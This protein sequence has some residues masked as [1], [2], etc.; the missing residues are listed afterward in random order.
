MIKDRVG[1]AKSR[2]HPDSGTL[3]QS[4]N[5]EFQRM[6]QKAASSTT[7]AQRIAKLETR[8]P[9]DQHDQKGGS[10]DKMERT[11]GHKKE[12]LKVIAEK[13][14]LEKKLIATPPELPISQNPPPLL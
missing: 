10:F 12:L 2:D 3:A 9:D 8:K 5:L 6:E 4:L 1:W 7:L 11:I 14:E 13:T